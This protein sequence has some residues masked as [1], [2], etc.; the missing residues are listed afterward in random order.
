MYSLQSFSISGDKK[1][2]RKKSLKESI[3]LD[4]PVQRQNNSSSGCSF[5][6]CF[7]SSRSYEQHFGK[8]AL[9][10]LRKIHCSWGEGDKNKSIKKS[11]Y[12]IKTLTNY[13]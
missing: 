9:F 11:K 1:E 12:A 6:N 2:V 10:R 8:T 7:I 13:G 4:P 3:K 5:W